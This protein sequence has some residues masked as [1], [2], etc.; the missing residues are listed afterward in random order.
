MRRGLRQVSFAD[1]LVNQRAGR[2]I[3][4]DEIDELI[5]WSAVVVVESDLC[6]RRGPAVLSAVDLREAAASAAV[7]F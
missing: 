3:W 6:Q 5:D 7:V 1:G 2:N 4:L